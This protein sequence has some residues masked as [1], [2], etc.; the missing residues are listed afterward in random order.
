M[1]KIMNKINLAI[2]GLMVAM[3]AFADTITVDSGMCRLFERLHGVFRVLQI[4]AFVG[5]A[6]YIAGWAWGF[7]SSGKAEMKDI[8]EKGTAL[9]VGFILLFM[10]GAILTF[11]MSV[12][13]MKLMGCDILQK[14]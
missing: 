2:I 13:G 7:I 6:F 11:V 10:I 14:W 12:S 9:L 8:K 4:L 5:A 3:P 1:K